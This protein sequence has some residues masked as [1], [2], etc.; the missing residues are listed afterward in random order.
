ML[1]KFRRVVTGH[2]AEG[3]SI[4]EFDEIV[5]KCMEPAYWPG[6][7]GTGIWSAGAPADNATNPDF[8]T[9]FTWPTAGSGGVWMTIMQVAPESDLEKMTPENRALAQ[10]PV[11]QLVPWA[12]EVDLSRSRTMHATNS[13]DYVMVLS[14]EITMLLDEGEVTLKPFDT[15]IQRGTNHAWVNRGKTAALVAVAAIDAKPLKRKR[16]GR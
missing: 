3:R 9:G 11:S 7:G 13:L 16:H 5:D 4:I 2:N 1:Q 6:M 12:L 8:G 15:L 14:G 10:R